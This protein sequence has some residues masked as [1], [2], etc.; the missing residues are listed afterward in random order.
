MK[1]THDNIN[2]FL[3]TPGKYFV[4]PDFQR[5]FSWDKANIISF[6]DDLE[7]VISRDKKHYFGSIVYINEGNN[8]TI[9]DGQQRATTV[10]LMLTAIYHIAIDR[11]SS[12]KISSEEIKEKYL[13]NGHD[14]SENASRIKLRTV[15]TDNAIFENIFNRTELVEN[16][17]DSKL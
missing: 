9:I 17:K 6:I 2:T 7:A 16:S 14:Y 13:Y 12:S 5:P 4:I 3:Y 8:S 15:T 1:V 11:P 10:L